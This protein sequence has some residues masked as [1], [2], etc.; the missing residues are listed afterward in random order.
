VVERV[1][2][3]A[4][5]YLLPPEQAPA[6]PLRDALF[7]SYEHRRLV[8]SKTA[9]PRNEV[10]CALVIVSAVTPLAFEA[11][12]SRLKALSKQ[13]ID[14]AEQAADFRRAAILAGSTVVTTPGY[15][16]TALDP[17][18]PTDNAT[19]MMGGM[20]GI[21]ASNVVPPGMSD[22]LGWYKRLRR[23][24]PQHLPAVR[25]AVDRLLGA[26]LSHNL[27]DQ[28]LD[29]GMAMEILLLHDDKEGNKELGHKLGLRAGWLLGSDVTTRKL[30]KGVAGKLYAARSSAAHEGRWT[31]GFDAPGYDKFVSGIAREIVARG[32]FPNWVELTFGG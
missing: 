11:K 18:F 23:F 21:V 7:E 28:A 10:H 9:A 32:E 6:A 17:D 16:S 3:D 5:I 14:K 12:D 24:R 26:R 20:D 27:A 30:N 31:P 25:I 29:L 15:Y 22:I 1:Q 4:G 2:V 13:A 19:L 8:L